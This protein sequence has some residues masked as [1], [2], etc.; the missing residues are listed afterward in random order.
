M[1]PLPGGLDRVAP[2]TAQLSQLCVHLPKEGSTLPR[3]ARRRVDLLQPPLLGRP[4]PGS[5]GR[6][7]RIMPQPPLGIHCQG[8]VQAIILV[9]RQRQ[10]E[11]GGGDRDRA[12]LNAKPVAHPQLHRPVI[13]R[14]AGAMNEQVA[15]A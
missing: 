10:A 4:R 6:M 12:R 9:T 5:A 14:P 11:G 2:A 13:R 8:E 15:H 7:I 1:S 3:A